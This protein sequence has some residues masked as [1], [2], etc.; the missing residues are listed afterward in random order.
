MKIVT[1]NLPESHLVAIKYLCGTGEHDV[2][3]SRSEFVRVAV[4]NQLI[5]DLTLQGVLMQPG[6]IQKKTNIN[7]I[8][9][10]ARLKAKTDE[11]LEEETNLALENLRALYPDMPE[12]KFIGEA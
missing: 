10:K 6:V 2:Y 12:Y 7:E 4:K 11:E 5:R 1:V 9:G 8:L 3:P